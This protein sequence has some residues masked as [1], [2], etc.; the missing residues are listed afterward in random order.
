MLKNLKK[1][2]PDTLSN[3][4]INNILEICKLVKS[5]Q[6]FFFKVKKEINLNLS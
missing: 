2:L 1:Y 3:L 4:I 6:D 5:W